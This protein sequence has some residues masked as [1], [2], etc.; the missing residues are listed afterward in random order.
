LTG[1]NQ[2]FYNLISIHLMYGCCKSL[3]ARVQDLSAKSRLT[4]KP[5]RWQWFSLRA[6]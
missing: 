5:D 4:I 3:H 1:N 2:I 6:L